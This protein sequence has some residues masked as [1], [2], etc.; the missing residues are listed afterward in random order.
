MVSVA[1]PLLPSLDAVMVTEP[2]ALAVT[3]P[4]TVTVARLS[5]LLR[6]RTGRPAASTGQV[7]DRWAEK[8]M[9]ACVSCHMPSGLHLFRI[10]ELDWLLDNGQWFPR[11]APDLVYGYG[12]IHCVTQQEPLAGSIER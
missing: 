11:Y 12:G 10:V 7:T 6:Q 2:T 8:P 9:E 3:R 5:S 4:V 1:E